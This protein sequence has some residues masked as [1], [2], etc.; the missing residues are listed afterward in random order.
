MITY[1][2]LAHNYGQFVLWCQ[3]KRLN[4]R[5]LVYFYDT[6]HQARGVWDY[7]LIFLDGWEHRHTDRSLVDYISGRA[8]HCYYESYDEPIVE[9]GEIVGWLSTIQGEEK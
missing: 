7:G 5:R 6:N 4:R 9:D 2:V 8:V 1:F 3:Q